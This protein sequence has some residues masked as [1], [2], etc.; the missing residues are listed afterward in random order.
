MFRFFGMN[1][2][3]L[4]NADWLTLHGGRGFCNSCPKQEDSGFFLFSFSQTKGTICKVPDDVFV[5]GATQQA[6]LGQYP[7]FLGA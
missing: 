2:Q 5:C 4:S 3:I 6:V 7:S 1:V